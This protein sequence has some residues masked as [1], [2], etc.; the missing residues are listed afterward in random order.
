MSWDWMWWMFGVMVA[1]IIVAT[2]MNI[3]W[4][5]ESERQE[6][7]NILAQLVGGVAMVVVG[8]LLMTFVVKPAV[9]FIAQQ[10]WNVFN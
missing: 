2:V 9:A 4:G 3:V 10:V 1:L 8:V 5:T 7:N 6:S